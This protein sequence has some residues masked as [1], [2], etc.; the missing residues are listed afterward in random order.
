MRIE[1]LLVGDELL[2]GQLDPYP[3][4]IMQAIRGEGGR[5]SRLVIVED[6]VAQIAAELELAMTRG[7]D[8]LLVT[9][10]LG[11]TIDD[12]TRHALAAYLDQPLVLD[13]QAERWVRDAISLRH[14][15]GADV[16]PASLLMAKVPEGTRALFNMVGVACGIEAVAGSMT[17]ICV[18]GFPKEMWAMFEAYFL[19]RVEDEGRFEKELWVMAGESFMEPIFQ[20]VAEEFDVRI[21][22]LPKEG[23]RETGNQ[24][25]LRGER[26]E[27]ERAARRFL[28]LLGDKTV[29]RGASSKDADHLD[30][31]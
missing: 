31:R 19:P 15:N 28:E 11:P 14:G 20:L 2:T 23:W 9:G 4:R 3:A 25:I 27:V 13:A 21:A 12:V 6:E 5:V 10:G 16:P 22:S 8:L 26:G 18:P 29:N 1:L 7:T 24:V 17:I 30:N